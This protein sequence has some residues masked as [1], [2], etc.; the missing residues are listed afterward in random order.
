MNGASVLLAVIAIP[1]GAYQLYVS[2][3]VYQSE[4]YTGNQRA[5]Q[6]IIIWL[7]PVIGATV[8]HSILSET[9]ST[10]TE[11]GRSEHDNSD[12]GHDSSGSGDG[13]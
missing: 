6:L 4:C 8:C 13:D 1:V 3:R 9:N 11:T 5:L 7:L 12:A 10:Y 2:W